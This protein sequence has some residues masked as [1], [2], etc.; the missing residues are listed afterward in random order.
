MKT[1]NRDQPVDPVCRIPADANLNDL[2]ARLAGV[3]RGIR[4][5][6]RHVSIVAGQER[7]WSGAERA[8]SRTSVCGAVLSHLAVDF[9]P[10]RLI[11]VAHQVLMGINGIGTWGSGFQHNV[12]EEYPCT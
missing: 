4:V 10:K 5:R 2:N 8:A 11:S 7:H 6:P 12:W 3:T 1:R 9:S